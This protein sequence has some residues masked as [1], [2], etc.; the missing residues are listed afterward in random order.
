MRNFFTFVLFVT[1]AAFFAAC[2][3]IM[4]TAWWGP[5]SM[6]I[7]LVMTAIATYFIIRH[8]A[9]NEVGLFLLLASGFGASCASWLMPGFASGQIVWVSIYMLLGTISAYMAVYRSV[10]FTSAQRF[11]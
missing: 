6:A 2:Q 4:P 9:G 3:T 10:A 5:T 8:N 11:A 7:M 1:I